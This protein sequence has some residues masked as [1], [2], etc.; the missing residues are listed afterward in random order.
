MGFD[1]P[2]LFVACAHAEATDLPTGFT[3]VTDDD[4]MKG[5]AFEIHSG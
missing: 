3:V 5:T 2:E 4:L 1:L